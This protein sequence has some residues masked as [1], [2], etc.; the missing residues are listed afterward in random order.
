MSTGFWIRIIEKYSEYFYEFNEKVDDV[1]QF[2]V[3]STG[4][5]SNYIIKNLLILI[6]FTQQIRKEK[7]NR[8]NLND[9]K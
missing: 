2:F 4:L 7:F 6:V 1:D 5:S 3:M 8:F 9:V